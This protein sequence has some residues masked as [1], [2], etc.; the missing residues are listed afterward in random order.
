MAPVARIFLAALLLGAAPTQAQDWLK[1]EPAKALSLQTGKLVLV[2]VACDPQTGMSRSCGSAGPDKAFQDVSLGKRLEEFYLVRV[3][4]KK[5]AQELKATKALEAIVVDGEGDEVH[6]GSFAD[7]K[8]LDQVLSAALQR[9]APREIAWSVPGKSGE[10]EKR[11]ALMA[12]V[13]ERRDSTELLKTLEDRTLAK[14][15]DRWTYLKI[16]FKRDSEEAKR[17]GVSQAPTLVFAD[18]ER[19]EAAERLSGRR[20]ARDLRQAFARATARLEARAE[21]REP[22][23]ERR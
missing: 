2:Y 6:R 12:F 22:T 23:G 1:F 3:C 19:K 16:P 4:D 10:G 7:A 9:Y 5:T 20:A 21:K 17:W 14:Q 8:G 15:Q 11:P 18:A 13:D